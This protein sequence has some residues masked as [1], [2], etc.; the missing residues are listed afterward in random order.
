MLKSGNTRP[1]SDMKCKSASGPR[2]LIPQLFD[3]CQMENRPQTTAYRP[4]SLRSRISHGAVH[5]CCSNSSH[6]NRHMQAGILLSLKVL[7][8]NG[9]KFH[10]ELHMTLPQLM[11]LSET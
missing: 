4:E 8:F 11:A 6:G 7:I 5:A 1:W 3:K 10:R 9:L 2:V